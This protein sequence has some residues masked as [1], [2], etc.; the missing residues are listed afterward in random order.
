MFIVLRRDLLFTNQYTQPYVMTIM[1][2]DGTT[3]HGLS[4]VTFDFEMK[5]GSATV[6]SEVCHSDANGQVSIHFDNT[7]N[8]DFT[9][10]LNERPYDGYQ[11]LATVTGN[12]SIDSNGTG[13]YARL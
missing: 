1:K 13:A 6:L 12:V 3:L 7:L 11:A 4:G 2:Q 5:N 9:F 8:G 10:T